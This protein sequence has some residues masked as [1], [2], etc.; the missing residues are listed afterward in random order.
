VKLEIKKRFITERKFFSM[1]RQV[2]LV[3]RSMRARVTVAVDQT[4]ETATRLRIRR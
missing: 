4:K 2:C 3:N 1:V